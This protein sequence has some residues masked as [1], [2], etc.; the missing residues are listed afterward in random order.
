MLENI[1][2]SSIYY[3][4]TDEQKQCVETAR[5]GKD[6]KIK[7]FAGSGKTSTLVAIAKELP[8]KGL[9]LAYNKAIQTDAARKFPSHVDCKTAHSI[10]YRATAYRIKDRVRT[11]SIFDI[12]RYVDIKRIYGYEENDIAFLVLKLLRVFVN[13]DRS[14][15][16]EQ[17]RFSRVFEEVAGNNGEETRAIINYVIDRA[18]EYWQRCTEREASLP[19]EHDFYLKMYQLSNPDLSN[20]YD[21][22]LFDECQDANPVL[23][24]ILLKQKCQKIYVGDEHQQIY[25]WRGSINSFAKLGGEVCYLSRSFRFGN[26]IS[27][28]ANII[29]AAKNEAQLLCGST[30]I[31]SKLVVKKLAAPFTIL[32]RT[33]A[34]II[35][36]ILAF[37]KQKLHVVGGVSEILNLAKSGYALFSGNANKVEHVKLKH[38]K[39]WSAMLQ[40]NHKYQDPDITFLAKLIKEHGASFKNIIKQIE[41]ACYVGESEA[42]VTLSTIHKS[43]GREW[44]NVVL[45]DDFIIFTNEVPLEEILVYD[46]EELNLIYVGITRTKAN[47]LLSTGVSSFLKRLETFTAKRMN[48]IL[49]AELKESAKVY[50]FPSRE[51]LAI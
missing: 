50:Q 40:F 44:D 3:Q 9:Y 28:L 25:S 14:K 7:A 4:L 12:T 5:C 42:A 19:I 15:I 24:D 20:V 22:I 48:L 38:F 6:L 34:R 17:F 11:L 51:V 16:D 10:A 33:N 41:D 46:V 29:I 39:S 35:E 13:S 45:E 30:S 27:R 8:G 18:A 21:F 36:K 37:Q 26:E 23:L 1:E 32:C 2:V 49:D 43:K 47:L 31:E